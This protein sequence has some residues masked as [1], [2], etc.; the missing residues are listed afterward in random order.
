MFEDILPPGILSPLDTHVVRYE[1]DDQSQIVPVEYID[2]L[3]ELIFSPDFRI[4]RRVI[5][6]IVAMH[7]A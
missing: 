5:D 4:D 1:I 7:R 6:D 2:K 3:A